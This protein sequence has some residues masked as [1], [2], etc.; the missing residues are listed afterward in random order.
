VLAPTGDFGQISVTHERVRLD[1]G[2]SFLVL[3]YELRRDQLRMDLVLS[4]CD[5]D[6]VEPIPIFMYASVFGQP[7]RRQR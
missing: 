7:Y 3:R 2:T 1:E 4:T 6:P 5:I